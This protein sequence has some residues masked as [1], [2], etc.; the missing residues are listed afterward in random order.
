MSGFEP[1]GHLAKGK[2]SWAD[3]CLALVRSVTQFAV[4]AAYLNDYAPLWYRNG[5]GG[6][7]SG[8]RAGSGG[9][10]VRRYGAQVHITAHADPVAAVT[11]SR[12]KQKWNLQYVEPESG[13]RRVLSVIGGVKPYRENSVFAD[14]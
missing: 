7:P 8:P 12:G 13:L 11:R 3:T 10:A 4:S 2:V 5:S 1:G 6:R 14:T 9:F